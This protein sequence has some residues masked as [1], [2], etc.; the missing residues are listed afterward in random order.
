MIRVHSINAFPSVTS[1]V[2]SAREPK[3]IRSLASAALGQIKS[4]KP[5]KWRVE[6]LTRLKGRMK[7]EKRRRRLF[8]HVAVCFFPRR[9]GSSGGLVLAAAAVAGL[10][11]VVTGPQRWVAAHAGCYYGEAEKCQPAH[12]ELLFAGIAR[13]RVREVALR[14]GHAVVQHALGTQHA[15]HLVDAL[16]DGVRSVLALPTS[17]LL[18]VEHLT[19]IYAARALAVLPPPPRLLGL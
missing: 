19:A 15:A 16:L 5:P 3:K 6:H 1:S 2:T 11:A 12:A 7:K 14:V 9:L 13:A 8:L 4:P 10:S 18:V 17:V